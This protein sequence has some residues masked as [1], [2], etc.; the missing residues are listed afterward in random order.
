MDEP[1]EFDR[2]CTVTIQG[3]GIF[4]LSLLGQLRALEEQDV[5][6]VAY[7]GTSAGAI[8]ATLAWAGY[9][10]DEILAAFEEL[11]RRRKLIGLV[12][13]F[14]MSRRGELI[15][16]RHVTS[17]ANLVQRSLAAGG[18]AGGTS[19]PR[20]LWNATGGRVIRLIGL[21]RWIPV[22]TR[23]SALV[24]FFAKLGLFQG[25]QFEVFIDG[26]LRRKLA[27]RGLAVGNRSVTFGDF[28]D[29]AFGTRGNGRPQPALF[30]TAT[31]VGR[32]DVEIV[33]SLQTCYRH[34]A[35]ARAVRASVGFPIFFRPVS[36][37]VRRSVRTGYPLAGMWS[38]DA[39]RMERGRY[40]D[41][42]V[43]ANFPMW[44]VNRNLREVLYDSALRALA[45]RPLFHVGLRL[46]A[47]A[48]H[49]ARAE[50]VDAVS[51]PAQPY[52]DLRQPASFYGSL[53]SMLTG[54]VR[55]RLEEQLV[56]HIGRAVLMH[57]QY[58]LSGAPGSVLA[59]DKLTPKAMREMFNQGAAAA[60]AEL[61]RLSF[62]L[63][64]DDD[65]IGTP[66]GSKL[67]A[68][69]D[70]LRQLTEDAKRLLQAA[71]ARPDPRVR[72][73]VFVPS[74][75]KLVMRYS[76]NMEGD[77]DEDIAFAN[78]GI[79]VTGL[80]I[81]ERH[82]TLYNPAAARAA[83]L[84]SL[85]PDDL[86]ARLRPGLNWVLSTPVID[87]QERLDWN[88]PAWARGASP[89][90]ASAP[91]HGG[92]SYLALVGPAKSGIP[93]AVLNVDAV[94]GDGDFP[95]SPADQL[96]RPEMRWITVLA[97]EAARKLGAVLGVAFARRS[98][99]AI[100]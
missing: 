33:N 62:G 35:V 87:P 12:G 34:I 3:G 56:G 89:R 84:A 30:L 40:V 17:I 77:P 19:L 26:L 41:G 83:G 54:G 18:N 20:R 81:T 67:P 57:Q 44:L 28:Y 73:N 53:L 74:E 65:E 88:A 100:A 29:A 49:S 78:F 7:A 79:G 8:V 64:R 32:G 15:R 69:R 59:F 2:Y 97:E 63:P 24:P 55:T 95:P 4:G 46:V 61:G 86:Y 85:V 72:A 14:E 98:A 37:L 36:M 31:N 25:R 68:I 9:T 50:T 80:C 23:S 82:M 66:D 22:V 96:E 42:G 27:E 48:K 91:V 58:A 93:M 51:H 38:G 45:F 39:S 11:A 6:P 75:G 47:D 21:L 71:G 1:G 16:P 60:R 94:V 92:G 43:V 90:P 52:E 70:I 10:A 13:P 5:L 76:V 99:G